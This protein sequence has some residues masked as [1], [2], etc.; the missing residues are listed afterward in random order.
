MS[1]TDAK[2]RRKGKVSVDHVTQWQLQAPARNLH[3]G[4]LSAG[5]Q[6]SSAQYITQ[7]LHSWIHRLMAET[8]QSW[9][10]KTYDVSSAQNY[11]FVIY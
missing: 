7:T 9:L 8:N 1:L 3:S 2:K 10:L 6:L 5:P 11:T 4:C